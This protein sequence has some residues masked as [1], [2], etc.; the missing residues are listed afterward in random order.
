MMCW[1]STQKRQICGLLAIFNWIFIEIGIT[2]RIERANAIFV[3]G[4]AISIWH[5]DWRDCLFCVCPTNQRSRRASEQAGH[6]S[7][8]D[9]TQRC[10]KLKHFFFI[11]CT[12]ACMCDGISSEHNIL[13]INHSVDS[14]CVQIYIN[15]AMLLRFYI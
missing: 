14:V 11:C 7:I 13:L 12:Y 1:V 9:F 4:R 5:N 10:H 15:F 2:N 6:I 8:K 3:V